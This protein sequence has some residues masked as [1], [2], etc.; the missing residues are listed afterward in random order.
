M[1]WRLNIWKRNGTGGERTLYLLTNYETLPDLRHEDS[2]IARPRRPPSP[3]WNVFSQ[4]WYLQHTT[5]HQLINTSE[6]QTLKV[7]PHCRMIPCSKME[8][9]PRPTVPHSLLLSKIMKN[10]VTTAPALSLYSF[11]ANTGSRNPR[12]ARLISRN[13][14]YLRHDFFMFI[15]IRC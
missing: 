9:T 1:T 11:A 14:C 10:P 7:H 12:F 3:T 15:L 2:P 4:D 5:K 6:V 8:L 13:S